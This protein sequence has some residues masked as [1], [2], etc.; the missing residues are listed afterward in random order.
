MEGRRE[1]REGGV[2]GRKEER[3]EGVEGRREERGGRT[4]VRRKEGTGTVG[5]ENGSWWW[6]LWAGGREREG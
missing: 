1:E 6:G 5:R 4:E 2:E 3:E